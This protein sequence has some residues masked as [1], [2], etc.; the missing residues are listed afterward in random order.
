MKL[1]MLGA[2]GAGKGTQAK[3]LVVAFSIPQVSTGDMLREARRQ[4]TELGR[5]AETFMEAG[6]LVPDDVVVGIVSQR[7]NADDMAR[8]FILD[9]FPRTVPQAE[10]LAG[11]GVQID[12]VV[13]LIVDENELINRLTGRLT[14]AGCGFIHH[15]TFMPPKIDGACDKCGGNLVQRADD[16]ET[17]VRNRLE[18]YAQQTEPLVAFYGAQGLVKNID[19]TGSSPDTVFERMK[20]ILE[21]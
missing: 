1:I 12:A 20:E 10:A 13:N 15:R 2:P 21:S 17:T 18:V 19:G 3:K 4:G 11:M 6:N 8:G 14:C 16:N 9:G 7:L 5:K